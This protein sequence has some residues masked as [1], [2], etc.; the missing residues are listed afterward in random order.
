MSSNGRP[1]LGHDSEQ[2]RASPLVPT[3]VY[4]DRRLHISF[5]ARH[6]F[7]R[8]RIIGDHADPKTCHLPERCPSG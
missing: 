4:M 8:H 6:R 5:F 2:P 1:R 7:I 3:L